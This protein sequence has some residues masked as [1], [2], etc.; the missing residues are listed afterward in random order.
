MVIV[1]DDIQW[2]QSTLPRPDRVRRRLDDERSAVLVCC[3]AR[4]ELLELRGAVEPAK[5]E[6]RRRSS[7][8]RWAKSDT[9][10]LIAN[11]L[12]RLPP[13]AD[14]A[15]A[16]RVRRRGQSVLRRGTAANAPGRGH[17]SGARTE[18]GQSTGDLTELDAPPTIHALLLGAA[19]SARA[20][21]T[22]GDP[23]RVSGRG[24]LLVGRRRRAVA[25]TD[26][27]RGSAPGCRHSQRTELIRAGAL[28][29]SP[30]RTLSA[31]GHILIRDAA[32]AALGRRRRARDL[33]ERLGWLARAEDRGP[34]GEVR[35]D[36]RLPPRAGRA[37]PTRAQR[38]RRRGQPRRWRCRAGNR[39][40]AAG[41]RAAARGDTPGAASL[42][43]RA[44]H[45][46]LPTAPRGGASCSSTS[47]RRCTR[48]RALAA[49]P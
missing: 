31:F 2:A 25:G 46:L 45:L 42:L 14:D 35:G 39:L 43:G 23:A 4:P 38:S 32:Y 7:S 13:A 28:G 36:R 34:G 26:C 9:D 3:L 8:S 11:L 27:V 47:R 22:S 15:E 29:R 44:A 17:A 30:T 18:A 5:A 21:G 10:E 12:G 49:N 24:G 41:R 1:F 37:L 20:R 6:L 40:A 16:D 19:R 33:H 48:W